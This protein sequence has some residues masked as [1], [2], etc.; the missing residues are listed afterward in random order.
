MRV[1]DYEIGP[2]AILAG[3]DLA[4]ANLDDAELTGVIGHNP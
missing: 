4:G 3:A 1:R 2:D